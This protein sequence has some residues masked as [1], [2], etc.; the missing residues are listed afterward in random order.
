MPDWLAYVNDRLGHLAIS[1]AESSQVR[2]ELAAHLEDNYLSLR[3]QGISESD[4]VRL[5]RDQVSSWQE[6]RRDILAAKS[7]AFMQ[8]RVSQLWIPGLVTLFSA[9]A[10]L[11]LM[12]LAGLRAMVSHPGEPRGIV[13]YLPWMLSL[14]LIGAIGAY[15]SR[16]AQAS[17][18]RVYFAASL[19]A[20][21]LGVFFL[22]IF[23][24][25]FVLDPHV[26]FRIKGTALA[27]MMVNWVILPAF[28]LCLGVALQSLR[29]TPEARS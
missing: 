6:L 29:K 1:Q 15:L 27:A 12:Q 14:P 22:L 20:L 16:R 13:L 7:E 19:P 26:P 21:A 2:E 24:L 10:V 11:A 28:A 8:N 9:Y 18:W 3:A 5:T 17:G 23:P 25:A 4:A